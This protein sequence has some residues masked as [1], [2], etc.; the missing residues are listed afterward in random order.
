MSGG[1]TIVRVPIH[2][3]LPGGCGETWTGATC[4]ASSCDVTATIGWLNVTLSSGASGTLP[5]GIHRSTLR[6]LSLSIVVA[7]GSSV[8]AG[9][10]KLALIA[11]PVRGGGEDFGRIANACLSV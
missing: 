2:R 8:D 9:G 10:G 11:L 3:Q 7:G 1:H 4:A 5:S 6:S